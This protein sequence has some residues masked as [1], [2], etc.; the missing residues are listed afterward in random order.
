MFSHAKTLRLVETGILLAIATVLNMIKLYQLPFGGEITFASSLPILLISYRHGIKWGLFSGF[1]YSL[2]QMATNFGAVK[3]LFVP[4]DYAIWASIGI[5]LLDYVFACMAL[6]LG[7]MFRNKFKSALA[8]CLGTVLAM[9]LK[10]MM[11]IIS[12]ILFFG[13]WA[14]WIFSQ[15]GFYAI[16]K[17]I[18][19]NFSGTGLAIIY[20]VFY[21]GLHMIPEIIV[22]VIIAYIISKV[23]AITKKIN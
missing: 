8:L 4:E 14:E 15:E 16:G 21:N 19:D 17:K 11:H 3:S 18:L 1:V 13:A 22:T 12:G 10:Y 2:L 9:L 5:I 23:P 6:G 20:S 7:G